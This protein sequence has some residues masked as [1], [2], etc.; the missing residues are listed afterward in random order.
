MINQTRNLKF[1]QQSLSNG[2]PELPGN[3]RKKL[4]SLWDEA[5]DAESYRRRIHVS[6]QETE[7]A[8]QSVHQ[9]LGFQNESE[10]N[11]SGKPSGSGNAFRRSMYFMA[12][13]A[14]ILVIGFAWLVSPVS[15]TVGPGQTLTHTLPDGSQVT[16]NS[17]SE[18]RYNRLFSHT[19]RNLQLNGE[20][21]FEVVASD[22]PFVITA[23]G[24][25]TEVIGTSFNL[26][27][28]SS[29]PE[30]ETVLSVT[31]GKVSFYN[32]QNPD[33]IVYLEE[34]YTSRVSAL[35]PVPS[36]PV[37]AQLSYVL[38]WKNHSLAFSGQPLA[39]IFHELERKFDIRIDWDQA[40]IGSTRLSTFIA[41]PDNAESVIA[42]ICFAKG[43]TYSR[44]NNGFR[45][46][47]KTD[48]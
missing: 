36:D 38:A 26:R 16:L 17:G 33:Q 10:G 40:E 24:S 2:L 22:N 7:V 6:E 41:D 44:T 48:N 30:V 32:E 5:R 37:S 13:A 3:E 21:Y 45:I 35:R 12:A 31:S 43:L 1:Q 46:S 23:N 47:K 8:L 25:V 34:G 39:I 27:S 18:I 9:K 19:N 15:T 28:W 14:A 29:D 20:A 4:K 11:S 42:D